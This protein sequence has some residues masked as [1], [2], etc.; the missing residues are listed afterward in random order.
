VRKLVSLLAVAALSVG[1]VLSSVA[2]GAT[3][4]VGVKGLTFSPKTVTVKKGTTVKWSW[5]TGGVPHNV[6]GK[7]FKSKTAAT[8]SFSKKFTKKGTYKYVCTIHKAQG[9]TGTVKVK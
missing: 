7:G 1:L 3:K 5:K 2:F 8:V 6:V 9:M 4:K